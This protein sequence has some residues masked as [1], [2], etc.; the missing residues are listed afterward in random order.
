MEYAVYFNFIYL[1]LYPC[2]CSQLGVWVKFILQANKGTE[3]TR[4][5][6]VECV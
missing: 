4:E 2:I 3:R 5:A 6:T 1:F